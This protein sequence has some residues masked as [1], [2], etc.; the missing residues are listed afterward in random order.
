MVHVAA[1]DL[2]CGAGGLTYGLEKAGIDVVAGVDINSHCQYP[3]ETNTNAEFLQRDIECVL[4]HVDEPEDDDIP[5]LDVSE[6]KYRL[7]D[8][9]VTV[10]AGCVPC[11]PYSNLSNGTNPQDHEKS[12]LL[13]AMHEVIKC[14]DPDIVAMENV[15]PLVDDPRYK[16]NF[17]S[18]FQENPAYTAIDAVHDCTNYGVPQA[19]ERLVFLAS[20][21]GHIETVDPPNPPK[22][23]VTV[24]HAFS[25]H[26]IPDLDAGEWR[27]DY[28]HLHKA[29]DL[30]GANPK[31]MRHTKE[32]EDWHDLPEDLKP[33][34]E[35]NSSYTAY[36][37]MWW[38]KPAPTLTTNFHNWGSGRFGHPNYDSNPDQ[39]TDRAISFFEGALLQTFPS[40]YQ[41]VPE[42]TCPRHKEMGEL[43]GNA[44]PVRLATAIGGSIR[45]HLDNISKDVVFDSQHTSKMS[46]STVELVAPPQL[47]ELRYDLIDK[48]LKQN[49]GSRTSV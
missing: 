4:D 29:A 39:S 27:P 43:I 47:D 48:D 36:G 38:D 9:A 11:Q 33:P 46:N 19:R 31:R 26:D 34:S 10:V 37:R 15:G 14:I 28:H 22:W 45:Q 2:F 16:L 8:T 30:R 42:D 32:G 3:Y 5:A 40:D 12:Q 49:R 6:L 1:V 21:F 35:A 7:P 23:E 18:W 13:E 20:K 44:V 24:R 17:K 41:F 25:Q